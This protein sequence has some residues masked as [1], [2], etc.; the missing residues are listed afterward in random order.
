MFDV[1]L[2]F[3]PN[4]HFSNQF[5]LRIEQ[6][7]HTRN[8]E[9]VDKSRLDKQ[10]HVISDSVWKEIKQKEQSI[11]KQELKIREAV[12]SRIYQRHTGQI[13]LNISL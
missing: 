10:K 11:L 9:Q 1:C 7:Q 5:K 6:M 4:L 13:V 12:F 8:S 3:N 2:Y